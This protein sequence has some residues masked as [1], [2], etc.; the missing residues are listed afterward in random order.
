MSE[1]NEKLLEIKRQ[2]DTYIIPENIKKD[3]TVYGVTGTLEPGSSGSGD[4]KLFDTVEHMQ[5]DPNP[6]EGDLAV[7]YR[8][9]L[10]PPSPG[11]TFRYFSPPATVIFDT[12]IT[13][14]TT[15]TIG[16]FIRVLNCT[17]TPTG[18]SVSGRAAIPAFVT[19]TYT[20]SDGVTYTKVAGEDDY[21]MGSNQTISSSADVNIL[22][23]LPTN[24]KMFEGLY[25]YNSTQYVIADSQLDVTADY[26]YKK[27]FYGTNGVETGTLT[28]SVNN[29]F[30]DVNAEV[31]SKIQKQYDNMTPRVLTDSDK[32][33][34]QGICIIPTKFDGTLLLD[35]SQV[36]NMSNMF[37]GCTS[38]VFVP[39][40]NTS[41]VTIMYAIFSGCSSLV[42]ISQLN[43]SSVV[44]MQNMFYNCSSLTTVPLLDTSNVINM[45]YMF[46]GCSSLT[47]VPLL[48]TGEVTNMN[49]IFQGC[50]SLTSI[51]LLDT[52]NVTN[53]G[54]MFSGC[55]SLTTIPL[56]D[57]GK[58][59]SLIIMFNGC[60]SL[61]NGSLNNILAMCIGATSYTDAKTLKQIGLTEAQTTTCQSLSNWS[62]FV[63]AGWTTGY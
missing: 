11:D 38:L 54:A 53:M 4:V 42:T 31:M 62:A 39:L 56:L 15:L 51:P 32:T 19:I 41:N 16:T 43:T 28:T 17:L 60:T 18:F 29:S 8:D 25:E 20:S 47:T 49:A 23:F 24:G 5:A 59:T 44:T 9:E 35:T 45:S 61:S 12:P 34:N 33:I 37:S 40:L 14:T 1:L 52:S 6:S 22:K 13:T 21:D 58:A 10:V 30:A 48:D 3:I 55:S 63:A 46:S 57:T 7:V 26:V 36:T 2:K 50:S 27:E